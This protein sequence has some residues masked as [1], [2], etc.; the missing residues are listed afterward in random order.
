MRVLLL[1]LL[2]LVA[3]TTYAQNITRPDCTGR[4]DPGVDARKR[5]ETITCAM[6]V[7]DT[8]H[9]G[10]IDKAAYDI[11]IRVKISEIPEALLDRSKIPSFSR[12]QE[13]CDC[14]SDAKI[15]PLEMYHAVHSCLVDTATLI[16]AHATLC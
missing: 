8:R 7:I 1:L 6:R 12:L 9:K 4:L 13:R 2:A 5:N 10:Y 11:Y 3:G 15:S 16:L 14:N